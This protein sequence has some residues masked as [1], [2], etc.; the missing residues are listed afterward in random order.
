MQTDSLGGNRYFVTFIDDKSRFT[1]VY[2][3]KI[4]DQVLE[5]LEEY[6]TMVTNMTD[7]KIKILRSDNCGEYI[8]KEFSN[9]L[10]VKRIQ[11]QFSILRTPQQIGVAERMDRTVQ[12]TA[13][14]MMHNVG[15]GEK[16]WAEAVCNMTSYK[17]FHGKK[18]DVSNFKVFG[19][20]AYM[21][22]RKENRKKWDSETKKSR[23]VGYSIT[24]KGY[25]LYD[26]VSGKIHVSRDVLFDESEFI[27][28]K[29]E[30]QIF[31]T[32][33]S[34]LMPDNEEKPY[35]INLPTPKETQEDHDTIDNGEVTEELSTS[36][37]TNVEQQQPRRSTRRREPP[38]RHGTVITGDWWLNNVAC[39]NVEYR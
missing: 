34:D 6:E 13:R 26:P 9:Y 23:F 14:S 37:E 21:H 27:H 33:D 35:E 32:N 28:T 29:E 30:T 38:D 7:K 39:T 18:P 31:D 10:K 1:A 2:F 24:N 12:E 11:R 36:E 19:C 5:K 15:L 22:V 3:M 4:K 8:S 17:C 25:G 20:I 16:F